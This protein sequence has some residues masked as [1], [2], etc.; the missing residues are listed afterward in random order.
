MEGQQVALKT[1][2][3]EADAADLSARVLES[4][5]AAREANIRAS[6]ADALRKSAEDCASLA[7]AQRE[8]LEIQNKRLEAQ[9]V[10]AESASDS[11]AALAD[12]FSTGEIH[13]AQTDGLATADAEVKVR[14]SSVPPS[15]LSLFLQHRLPCSSLP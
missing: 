4:E 1:V 10:V 5:N 9:L 13:G 2:P 3:S 11:V 14:P 15:L 12:S 6:R 7:E 8:R